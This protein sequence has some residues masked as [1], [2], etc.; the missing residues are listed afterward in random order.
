MGTEVL[1]SEFGA[2]KQELWTLSSR[3]LLLEGFIKH[4]FGKDLITN[5]QLIREGIRELI[6]VFVFNFFRGCLLAI[7]SRSSNR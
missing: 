3:V 2:M 4:Q 6:I 5:P 1:D 7:L